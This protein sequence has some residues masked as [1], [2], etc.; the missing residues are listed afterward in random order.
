MR[1]EGTQISLTALAVLSRRL[2]RSDPTV[3]DVYCTIVSVVR[4]YY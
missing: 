1:L 3:A 2:I 4:A